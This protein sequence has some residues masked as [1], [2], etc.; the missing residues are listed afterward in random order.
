M[1][2]VAKMGIFL[3]LFIYFFISFKQFS[4]DKNLAQGKKLLRKHSRQYLLEAMEGSLG[5]Q[6]YSHQ[7]SREGFLIVFFSAKRPNDFYYSKLTK[8]G[9]REK[10]LSQL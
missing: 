4:I 10:R 8:K 3:R 2:D 7:N 5:Q 1:L 6:V 9:K